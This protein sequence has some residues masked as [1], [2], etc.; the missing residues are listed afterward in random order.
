MT[1]TAKLFCR[2]VLEGQTHGVKSQ[3]SSRQK[4]DSQSLR[5]RNQASVQTTV[6]RPQPK[7]AREPK[8]LEFD[9]QDGLNWGSEIMRP[10]STLQER[11]KK[12]KQPTQN[13][14]TALPIEPPTLEPEA[15]KKGSVTAELRLCKSY[16][17]CVTGLWHFILVRESQHEYQKI[18]RRIHCRKASMNGDMTTISPIGNEDTREVEE[19]ELGTVKVENIQIKTAEYLSSSVK[20]DQC[21]PPKLPEIAVIGRSNVGKSSLINLLTGRK[22]LALVSK[23]PG[24]F[25]IA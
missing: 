6:K 4:G 25:C 15:E 1:Q 9:D 23:T 17:L 19:V 3:V 13:L 18:W 24:T 21:P 8:A 20:M 12:L 10:S 16:V 14:I 5:P 11:L 7:K 22:D 2:R